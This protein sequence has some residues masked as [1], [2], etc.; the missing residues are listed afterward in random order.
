MGNLRYPAIPLV[1]VDPYFS[2]WSC[3]DKLYEDVTRHWTGRRQNMLGLIEIDG[4]FYRF[5]GKVNA[6]NRYHNEPMCL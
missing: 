6:D 4:T 2:I 3:C 5:M 1:T